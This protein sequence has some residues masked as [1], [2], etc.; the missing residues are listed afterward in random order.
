MVD[1]PG[2]YVT[3]WIKRGPRGVIGTNRICA[4]ETVAALLSDF[5]AGLLD[6]EISDRQALGELLTDRGSPRS[7]GPDGCPSMRPNGPGARRYRVRAES[8][9]RW[10][11]CSDLR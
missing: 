7:A 8:S 4:A 5:D 10:T 1:A 3:G 2:A 11:P 6:R 9:S